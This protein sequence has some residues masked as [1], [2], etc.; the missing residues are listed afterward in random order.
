MQ[1]L[2]ALARRLAPQLTLYTLVSALALA[3]D[4]AFYRGLTL[5]GAH[6]VAAGMTAYLLGGIVH[7]ILSVKYVF[8]VEGSAKTPLRRFAE[9]WASGLVGLA[10]TTGII[11]VGVDMLHLPPMIAKLSAVGFS[12]VVIYIIRRQVV[13]AQTT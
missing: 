8:D 12:F 7:Y 5:S 9:F 4:L 3:T 11:W 6:P 1:Q 13:F 2:L 10:V